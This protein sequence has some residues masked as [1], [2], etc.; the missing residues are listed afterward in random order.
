MIIYK[1]IK[2]YLKKKTEKIFAWIFVV[3]L[4]SILGV[5][6][7]ELLLLL[8]VEFELFVELPFGPRG[9]ILFSTFD[10][11]LTVNVLLDGDT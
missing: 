5:S 11:L 3:T 2:I 9:G 1:L 4:T 8:L 10:F 7:G 6:M